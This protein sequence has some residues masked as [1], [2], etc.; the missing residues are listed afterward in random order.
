MFRK[1]TAISIQGFL[2]DGLISQTINPLFG[3]RTLELPKFEGHGRQ[4]RLHFL[5]RQRAV[6]LIKAVLRKP[7]CAKEARTAAR[8]SV[9]ASCSCAVYAAC[10]HKL[11]F[12]VLDLFFFPSVQSIQAVPFRRDPQASRAHRKAWP[13]ASSRKA[14][15]LA[16]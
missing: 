3:F 2:V 7:G 10:A 1:C 4:A 11:S 6:V 13:Q 5:T 9:C 8:T 14:R 15:C 12:R 16:L